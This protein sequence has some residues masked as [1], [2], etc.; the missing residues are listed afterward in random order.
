MIIL[1]DIEFTEAQIHLHLYL[2]VNTD[3]V[4]I[5]PRISNKLV[6]IQNYKLGLFIHC[7]YS[8]ISLE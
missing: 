5:L 7:Q 1:N 8:W 3:S 4:V 2:L 6:D